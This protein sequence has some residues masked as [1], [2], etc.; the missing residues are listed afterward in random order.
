MNCF[1]SAILAAKSVDVLRAV[2]EM[3]PVDVPQRA[4]PLVSAYQ[5][6]EKL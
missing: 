1:E 5:S 4:I 6:F 2:P 3:R